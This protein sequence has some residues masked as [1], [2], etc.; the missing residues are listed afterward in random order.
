[1]LLS[2]GVLAPPPGAERESKG[3]D[4]ALR[5]M[6]TERTNESRSLSKEDVNEAAPLLGC[7]TLLL[8]CSTTALLVLCEGCSTTLLLSI[9]PPDVGRVRLVPPSPD[10]DDGN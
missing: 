9:A 2:K 8:G 10:E 7:S 4:V 5:W 1:M 6:S 3:V